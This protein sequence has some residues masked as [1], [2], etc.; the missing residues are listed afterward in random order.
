MCA[1]FW[2]FFRLIKIH[3]PVTF[4]R[5]ILLLYTTAILK[6][7]LLP[8]PKALFMHSNTNTSLLNKRVDILINFEENSHQH[9]LIWRVSKS[10]YIHDYQ[11]S[12]IF[13]INTFILTT[14]LFGR[15]DKLSWKISC[16]NL[17][18]EVLY[19]KSG[20]QNVCIL[21][22]SKETVS[23]IIFNIADQACTYL[24]LT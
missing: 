9:G 16:L 23:F 11:F 20:L 6:C 14:R 1:N 21:N 17:T 19:S 5:L 22:H 3:A 8:S 10:T 7:L 13:P 18:A 4:F 2:C 24:S 12:W 15:L